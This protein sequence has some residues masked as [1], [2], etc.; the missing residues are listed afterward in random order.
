MQNKI[1]YMPLSLRYFHTAPS[2]PTNRRHVTSPS[3]DTESPTPIKDAKEAL[4]VCMCVRALCVY[5][6]RAFVR[7]FVSAREGVRAHVKRLDEGVSE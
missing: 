6:A 7:V 3:Q 5:C 2:Y 1:H 4:C